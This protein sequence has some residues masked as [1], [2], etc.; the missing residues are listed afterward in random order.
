MITVLFLDFLPLSGS[1]TGLQTQV[2]YMYTQYVGQYRCIV[3]GA[4]GSLLE[5]NEE[6]LPYIFYGSDTAI[7][8]TE[9]VYRPFA[10]IHKYIQTLFF[11]LRIAIKENPDII[12][13]YHY[14]W[15]IYAN[16][17][18]FVLGKPVIIHLKDVW[19]LQP[20]LARVLMKFNPFSWYIAVSRYVR[21]LFVD[22]Y[23]IS[24]KKTV[25]I[26]DGID[27]SVFTMLSK[28]DIQKKIHAQSKQIIMMSRVAPERDIEIFIDVAALIS[29]K[30]NNVQFVHY[31]YSKTHT[32]IEYFHSL[33]RRVSALAIDH[34]FSFHEYVAKPKR[35]AEILHNSYLMLVP[36][37]RFA[38]PNSAIE[39]M[40]CSTPVLAYDVGGNIEIIKDASMGSVIE[41]NSPILYADV[42]GRF[43]N[44]KIDYLGIAQR[45]GAYAHETFS[46]NRIFPKIISLYTRVMSQ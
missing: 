28:R 22:V 26:Y 20:K 19:L 25:Q 32:S 9:F 11:V 41:V 46:V 14:M 5:K 34:C 7:E 1:I 16:P 29:K 31:G 27:G 39:S 44:G 43:L 15:S 45:A 21:T 38:L 23:K 3:I 17:V 8:L 13:C 35:V 12:H 42:I 2:R 40:M 36:A 18:G 10:T 24:K 33:K 37:R 30:Y 6:E 4:K